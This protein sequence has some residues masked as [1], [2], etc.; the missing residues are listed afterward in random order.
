MTL[1]KEQSPHHQA[2]D[3]FGMTIFETVA[4]MQEIED[5][6]N[7]KLERKLDRYKWIDYTNYATC[8]KQAINSACYY[9]IIS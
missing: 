4:L 3:R 6:I 8:S 7:E 9:L 1:L 5:E 2:A